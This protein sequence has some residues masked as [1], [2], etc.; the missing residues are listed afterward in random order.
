MKLI[1]PITI[2][3]AMLTSSNSPETDYTAW[4]GATAY[5]VG[6]YC[7]L[8]STHKI[9]QCM[10]ANTNFS[11]DVNLTGLTPKWLQI[12]A[13]NRWKM[14]DAISG[15]QT[16]IA[17]PLTIVLTPAQIFNS[18]ALLNV[19]ASSITVSMTVLGV[20]VYSSTVS[21][22]TGLDVQNWY[23]F[24]FDP[25]T[26]KTDVVFQDIPPYSN[27]IITITINNT[28]SFAACGNC[29]I[30]NSY[31]MGMTQYGA[32][33]GITDYSVK[34]V[35]AFGNM[36]IT[37]RAYSKRMTVDL[38]VPSALVDDLATVMALYRSTPIVWIGSDNLYTCLIVYG[39]YR[40]FEINISYPQ[41]S[42]CSLT[43]EGLT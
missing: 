18:L 32:K 26:N 16:S 33:A 7:I 10:I 39:F 15:T 14:F 23:G 38:A 24:F 2:T 27:S 40:D 42:H 1:R 4:S 9:Y 36:T 12:G 43:I 29:V 17:T 30:G 3:G 25:I 22:T 28:S 21:M 19:A 34:T 31:S 8:A 41:I 5:T 6:Q 20:N 13:T 11:P 35:D 37:P